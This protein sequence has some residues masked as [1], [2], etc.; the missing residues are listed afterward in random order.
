[1][2]QLLGGSCLCCGARSSTPCYGFKAR[3]GEAI[4]TA[5]CG[6]IRVRIGQR[7]RSVSQLITEKC[8]Q[9][10]RAAF[11]RSLVSISSRP[12]N[13]ST[14]GRGTGVKSGSAQQLCKQ[15][16]TLNLIGTSHIRKACIARKTVIAQMNGQTQQLQSLHASKDAICTD[17]GAQVLSGCF[18]SAYVKH[19]DTDGIFLGCKSPSGPAALQDL[20]LGKVTVD[21]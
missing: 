12:H 15:P 18:T 20:Q 3:R 9:R 11:S 16:H 13:A 1:M 6:N 21:T 14:R 4:S 2:T 17:T 10:C 5:G 8:M 7:H 19:A